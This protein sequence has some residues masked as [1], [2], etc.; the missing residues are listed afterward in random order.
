MSQTRYSQQELKIIDAV[1]DGE[2]KA[3]MEKV[4]LLSLDEDFKPD[5]P[6]RKVFAEKFSKLHTKKKKGGYEK[7]EDDIERKRLAEEVKEMES[8]EEAHFEQMKTHIGNAIETLHDSP[9]EAVKHLQYFGTTLLLT[10]RGEDQLDD[11]RLKNG[12]QAIRKAKLTEEGLP[13]HDGETIGSELM[14][15]TESWTGNRW[16]FHGKVARSTHFQETMKSLTKMAPLAILKSN[17]IGANAIMSLQNIIDHSLHPNLQAGINIHPNV[18]Q[19]NLCLFQAAGKAGLL[20][21]LKPH[22]ELCENQR[23][24][25]STECL[26][27][28]KQLEKLFF[29]TSKSMDDFDVEQENLKETLERICLDPLKCKV[30]L[31]FEKMSELANDARKGELTIEEM[32]RQVL[33]AGGQVEAFVLEWGGLVAFNER[34]YTNCRHESNGMLDKEK[35]KAICKLVWEKLEPLSILGI[36]MQSG[37]PCS[38]QDGEET[39]PDMA[40]YVTSAWVECLA[41]THIDKNS[42]GPGVGD[43]AL[44][45]DVAERVCKE[46]GAQCAG[47]FFQ[48]VMPLIPFTL[49]EFKEFSDNP[50]RRALGSFAEEARSEMERRK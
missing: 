3:E 47:S 1:F 16:N 24:E 49:K 27:A 42:Y 37:Y 45:L 8:S 26:E 5:S 32:H 2:T 4:L 10:H 35:T 25:M 7:G 38:L 50:K 13:T 23:K 43:C 22:G 40:R 17:V 9:R 41:S 18:V 39:P 34:G 31:S 28:W 30:K 11:C 19:L 6:L 14:I 36:C 21:E 20:P 44:A 12:Y 46:S 29:D 33:E 15:R 48:P